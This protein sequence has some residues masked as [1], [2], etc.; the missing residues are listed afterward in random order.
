MWL[1][2]ESAEDTCTRKNPYEEEYDKAHTEFREK[3]G[4]LGEKLQTEGE[5]VIWVKKQVK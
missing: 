1:R 2:R 3:Y 4:L 5:K